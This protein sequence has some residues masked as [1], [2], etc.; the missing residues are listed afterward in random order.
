MKRAHR[1]ARAV[2]VALARTD[3]NAFV[4]YVMKDEENPT[5]PLKQSAMHEAWHQI[6]DQF[7]R[8]V[9]FSFISSGKS[10][11]I[12][13]GRVLWELG[14]NSSIRVVIVSNTQMQAEKLVRSVATYVEKSSELHE[15]FPHLRPATPWNVAMITIER[16]GV[17]KDPTVQ[18]VGIHSNILGA[19]SDLVVLDDVCDY[20]NSRTPLQRED[21]ISWVH[22]AL[23]GR[24]SAKG[25]IICVG[26]AQN[27]ED[28][29]HVLSA[30]PL[31]KCF[32]FAVE[33]ADG[34]PRWPARWPRERIETMRRTLSPAEGWRQLDV[35]AK[36]DEHAC[37]QEEWIAVALRNGQSPT[38][39]SYHRGSSIAPAGPCLLIIPKGWRTVL[40]VDLAFS[41]KSRSALSAICCVLVHPTG[42]R[43]IL[44]CEAGKWHGPTLLSRILSLHRRFNTS[45]IVIEANQGQVLLGQWLKTVDERLPLIPY[46]TGAG[47]KSLQARIEQLAGEMAHG[48]WSIPS[49]DG[50][51]RDPETAL[52]IRDLLSYSPRDHVPDRVAALCMAM[53][54][55][56][57]GERKAEW[58]RLSDR[59][60]APGTPWFVS[61][62]GSA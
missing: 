12:S 3:V 9:I 61:R 35:I 4:T 54:G 20:E 16:S 26:T 14:R 57:Q 23:F 31:W 45:G 15:V 17:A 60:S 42:V 5:V 44:S 6:L 53:V 50:R 46:T 28:L 56:E 59:Y 34:S 40:G 27:R 1:S 58:G 30:R 11:Q 52:L 36:S 43:E 33:N 49:V 22:N 39:L 38:A 8:V 41:Q 2:R 13:I 55:I 47:A 25:R 29:M 62:E 10:Q 32:R 18:G 37:I 51:A 7:S 21:L 19:R 24:L 48:Q